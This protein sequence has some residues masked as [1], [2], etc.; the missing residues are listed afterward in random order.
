MH[1]RLRCIALSQGP[2]REQPW[3]TGPGGLRRDHHRRLLSPDDSLDTLIIN[4][5]FGD[6]AG[7]VIVG[8][9]TVHPVEHSLVQMV[10]VTQTVIPNTEH[11]LTVELGAFGI[12]AKVSTKLPNIVGDNIEH[13][14]QD[15]FAPLAIDVKWND[16]FW[17]VH[18]GSRGVLDH[19][20]KILHLEP[21]KLAA[22][23]TV[24][25]KFGNLLGAT[26]IFV[27]EEQLRRMEEE[28]DAAEWGVMLGFGPGFTMETMVLRSAGGLKKK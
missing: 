24:V 7:A 12:H 13:C 4:A 16:L 18:P 25:Q 27:L 28:G 2:S 3:R 22:S 17:A 19:I 1:Y 26:V 15:A 9:D 5:L 21:T 11:V 23:R 10:S 14:L 20:D 8:A 6:G